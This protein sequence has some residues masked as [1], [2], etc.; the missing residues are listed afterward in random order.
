MVTNQRLDLIAR[1]Y[2]NLQDAWVLGPQFTLRHFAALLGAPRYKVHAK[3]VGQIVLRPRSSDGA[4]FRQTFVD[5]SYALPRAH[6]TRLEARYQAILAQ[7]KTPLVIDAGANVGA[8]SRWFSAMYP[9]AAVIAVEPEASNLAILRENTA[10]RSQ[11]R[12]V[13]AAIGAEAGAVSLKGASDG[14]GWDVRTQRCNGQ[15]SAS[16]L[17]PVVTIPELVDH[18]TQQLFIVKVDIEGFEADLFGSNLD[19]IDEVACLFV[20]PHDWLLPEERSSQSLQRALLGRGF[21][22]LVIGENLAF[23]R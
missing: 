4:A 19:W 2:S 9:Q 6:Q 22:L 23:V 10:G 13:A 5:C 21:D 18:T 16:A 20:E 14:T 17:V 3:A 11:V 7:G 12:V 8:A 15:S 1:L